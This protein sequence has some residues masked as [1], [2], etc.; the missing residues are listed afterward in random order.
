MKIFR[1]ASSLLALLL[2]TAAFSQ[3][4]NINVYVVEK[5]VYKQ[6]VANYNPA[7][8]D[9]TILVNGTSRPFRSVYPSSGADYATGRKWYVYNERITAK[10]QSFK[11][12]GL[13]R[14]LGV[15]EIVPAGTVDGVTFFVESGARPPYA[16]IYVPVT[17][18]GEFQPYQPALPSCG[19]LKTTPEIQIYRPNTPVTF[20]ASV[21]G[22]KAALTYEWTY[23]YRVYGS[24]ELTVTP[25]A[26]GEMRVDVRAFSKSAGCESFKTLV[27]GEQ[28][29]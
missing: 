2:S 26:W 23:E 27:I 1:S 21:P 17:S 14:V 7:N 6:V 8:G 19:D 24:Q 28:K 18:G 11:K 25:P 22:A 4:R 3:V 10:G 13:P 5:G 9:T 16:Y 12:L 15:D 29:K 20:K